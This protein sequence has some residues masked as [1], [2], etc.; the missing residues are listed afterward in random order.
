MPNWCWTSMR[1]HGNKTEIEDFHKK[2]E[3]FTSKNYMENCFGTMWL[4]NILCGAGLTDHINNSD[5]DLRIRCRGQIL[6]IDDIDY[7]FEEDISFE[8]QYESAWAWV[9]KMWFKLIETLG[10]E[11]VGFSFMSEETGVE[12]YQ[13]YDP[14][15]DF[16]DEKWYVDSYIEGDDFNDEKLLKFEDNRYY[17]S[18]EALIKS[19]QNLLET[20]ETDLDTL[21]KKSEE[22]KFKH[23]DSYIH[24]H[25]YIQLSE[26][27]VRSI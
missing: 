22:Y 9:G 1:F 2:L 12:L 15:G 5:E 26:D 27:E 14:Y 6:Y 24:I 25:E 23:E 3:E 10:Y 11:S 20:D 4:G 7:E 13:K 21:L 18:D 19:L 16:E 17:H 8:V